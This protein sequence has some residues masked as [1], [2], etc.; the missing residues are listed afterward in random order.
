MNKQFDF[1]AYPGKRQ[2]KDNILKE[3]KPCL[4]IVTPYYNSKKYFEETYNSV[5]NQTF[6]NFEWIIVDDKSNRE[7]D[8]LYLKNFENRDS[9]IRIF[10]KD[11]NDGAAAT[12]NFGI[13]QMRS[14]IFVPLNSDDLFEPEFL[15]LIYVV[16]YL[17]PEIDCCYTNSVGFLN[18]NY[19]WDKFLD[20]A[21]MK[22]E[23]LMACMACRKKKL[24]EVG[25]YEESFRIHYEDWELWLKL[26]TT[27]T[28]FFR[29][30]S[31]LFWYRRRENSALRNVNENSMQKIKELSEGVDDNIDVLMPYYENFYEYSVENM[32]QVDLVSETAI[33]Q[34]KQTVMIFLSSY[35]IK[36][37]NKIKNELLCSRGDKEVILILP[38]LG[39]ALPI[40]QQW[41]K[42]EIGSNYVL[43]TFL[44]KQQYLSFVKYILQS[45]K[46]ETIYAFG[47]FAK[48]LCGR[49]K[50][51]N[52]IAKY[53]DDGEGNGDMYEDYISQLWID[54]EQNVVKHNKLL[55]KNDV[56]AEL[57]LWINKLDEAKKYLEH[58]NKSKELRI[59]ELEQWIN[60]NEK[61]KEYLEVQNKNK[62]LRIKE[63]ERWLNQVEKGKEYLET[64]NRNKELRIVELEQW[65]NQVE[66]GKEYLEDQNGKKE[67]QIEELRH[68]AKEL[69]K[70]RQ[71]LEN[72]LAIAQ[73]G[74]E[75][76]EK[77][78]ESKNEEYI[79]L[80]NKNS[81]LNYKFTK[82]VED[83]W[84]QKIIQL[85]K[86]N[87]TKE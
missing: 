15:E 56:N 73:E 39:E 48:I 62:E 87:I 43:S 67:L 84:I 9:R 3:L 7:E 6:S 13:K 46:I 85:K 2:E 74:M 37:I 19:L 49:L 12:L 11:S 76:L 17:N 10:Y 58:Q 64:Q 27:N 41:L 33:W 44:N 40:V 36:Q 21:K 29:I 23:N 72:K 32:E 54:R 18:Q 53:E 80:K 20:P 14:D 57:E 4:S 55:K 83:R 82:L 42:K 61:G 8:I 79:E 26:L 16:F 47:L 34:Q 78:L 5:M 65:L 60:T 22:Y 68:W 81:K 50:K 70:A 52:I 35:D 38:D 71:W 59:Q 66:K 45:R 77:Q 31:Y 86:Y 75:D 30:E 63:L 69:E 25:G 51:E 28:K 1:N 24:I